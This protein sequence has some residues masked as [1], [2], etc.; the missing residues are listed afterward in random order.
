MLAKE[1][2]IS[3]NSID[4][5]KENNINAKKII[6]AIKISNKIYELTTHKK[7]ISDLI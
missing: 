7:I 2:E 3:L 5:S 6:S 4:I 1:A